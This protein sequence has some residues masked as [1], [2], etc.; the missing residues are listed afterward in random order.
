MEQRYQD[1]R[2]F[3]TM[4]WKQSE[5]ARVDRVKRLFAR[6]AKNHTDKLGTLSDN[7]LRRRLKFPTLEPVPMNDC[8]FQV[9]TPFIH[10]SMLFGSFEQERVADFELN[11]CPFA[12]CIA[13]SQTCC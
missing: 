8:T 3:S 9:T 7:T 10:L 1:A 5:S 12:L 6:D 13:C 2:R 11:G 4:Q